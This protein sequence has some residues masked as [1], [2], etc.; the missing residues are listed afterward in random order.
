MT[1]QTGKSVGDGHKYSEDDDAVREPQRWRH[2]GGR[3]RLD[4]KGYIAVQDE[5]VDQQ[6]EPGEAHHPR[7]DGQHD[8]EDAP[9]TERQFNLQPR[10]QH[11]QQ[12]S[13]SKHTSS[14]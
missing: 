13:S 1:D 14:D 11:G 12:D 9:Y 5:T 6:A 4:E 7:P 3:R 10:H 2:G 8:G